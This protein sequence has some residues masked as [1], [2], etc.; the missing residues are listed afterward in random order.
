M[1]KLSMNQISEDLTTDEQLGSGLVVVEPPKSEFVRP[2]YSF[3]GNTLFPYTYG[4]ELLFNQVRDAEDTGLFTWLAFVYLLRKHDPSE[5][6]HTHRKWAIKLAWK[7]EDFRL[8]LSEWMD[9]SGP[10]T[11]ED[12][13]EAKRIYE[14]NMKAIA[15]TSVE[16]VPVRGKQPQKK[17]SRQRRRL[18]SMSSETN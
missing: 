13:L 9:D 17:T 5:D 6:E 12:K 7:V 11:N 15:D 3:K 1:D 4:Y 2:E 16:A 8:A 14:E 10:F 18:S